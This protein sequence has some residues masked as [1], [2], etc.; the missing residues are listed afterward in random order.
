[1]GSKSLNNL[2]KMD[3]QPREQKQKYY[4]LNT[5]FLRWPELQRRVKL[6][7]KEIDGLKRAWYIC[8]QL[9]A[10]ST[11][12]LQSRL[13]LKRSWCFYGFWGFEEGIPAR[14]RQEQAS[15]RSF[16]SRRRKNVCFKH[17]HLWF[18]TS[19]SVIESNTTCCESLHI[20]MLRLFPKNTTGL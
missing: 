4:V 9:K 12:S 20:I 16:A 11:I 8:G 2:T 15:V 13:L 3:V 10:P 18:E 17:Y 5:P 19:S 1:M 6:G 14:Q 7:A